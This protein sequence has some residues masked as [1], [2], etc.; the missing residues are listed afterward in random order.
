VHDDTG[1]TERLSYVYLSDEEAAELR[2]LSDSGVAVT[3][4]DVPTARPIEV[5]D[6]L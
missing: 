4:Q 1:R 6:F 2:R 5:G 3:A